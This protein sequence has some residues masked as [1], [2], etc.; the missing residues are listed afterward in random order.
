MYV[1]DKRRDGYQD[2]RLIFHCLTVR[3]YF[4]EELSCVSE[5]SGFLKIYC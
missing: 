1:R 5:S 4:V 3:K 2:S